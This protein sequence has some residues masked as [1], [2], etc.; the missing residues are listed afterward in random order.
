MGNKFT[1]AFNESVD[2]YDTE[3][4]ALREHLG[5]ENV[6]PDNFEEIQKNNK[7]LAIDIIIKDLQKRES[8]E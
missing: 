7:E 2:S 3:I 1:G 8:K 5:Y 4:I 6:G